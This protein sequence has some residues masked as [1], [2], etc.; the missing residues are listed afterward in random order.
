MNV[1]EKNLELLKSTI[2]KLD[3]LNKIILEISMDG[4]LKPS[5]QSELADHELVDVIDNINA[6]TPEII[7]ILNNK[8]TQLN[9]FLEEL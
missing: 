4:F 9:N 3:T 7:E 5:L 1:N 8:I 2:E 6:K